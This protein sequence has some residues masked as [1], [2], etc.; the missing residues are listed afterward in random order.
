MP[1]SPAPPPACPPSFRLKFKRGGA[2]KACVPGPLFQ[3]LE[4]KKGSAE[5]A[6]EA[7]S[8]AAEKLGVPN[9]SPADE[10]LAG[11]ALCADGV[12]P[13]TVSK[14]LG[15]K[16]FEGFCS[17]ILRT[18]GYRVRENIYLRRPR[19]QVD[20]LGISDRISLAVDCK[21]WARSPGRGALGALVAA[22]K[23]RARRLHDSLDETEGI[24]AVILVV[25][26]GGERFVEGGAVVP[27]FVL[28]DFLDNVEACR[29]LLD[30]V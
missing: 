5:A 26:D 8:A 30:L 10:R 15:W 28:G 22:Q 23:E 16:A 9:P 20:V 12:M 1:N 11:L 3:L 4:R 25:V 6:S 2:S 21:H 27:V 29:G 24:A 19:A 17:D 18:K 7:I 14:H 13:E